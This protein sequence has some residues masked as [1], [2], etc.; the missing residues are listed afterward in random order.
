M[1]RIIYSSQRK[2]GF[3]ISEI[4]EMLKLAQENN[5]GNGLSGML[6]FG[7]DRFLQVLEGVNAPLE[8]LYSKIKKDD[9]HQNLKT[10]ANEEIKAPSF[11]L[12][13]M[14]LINLDTVGMGRGTGTVLKEFKPEEMSGEEAMSFL[15]NLGD[16]LKRENESFIDAKKRIAFCDDDPSI[17]KVMEL[18]LR[19]QPFEFKSYLSG[20]ELY[21]DFDDFKPD[22]IISD[23][24]MPKMDGLE[25]LKEIRKKD[26]YIPLLFSTSRKLDDRLERALSKGADGYLQKPY[27]QKDLLRAIKQ[28]ILSSSLVRSD[29]LEW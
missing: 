14:L 11:D 12:W 16:F 15:K 24:D 23:I 13:S 3:K 1:Q 28:A 26:F 27:R 8:A 18:F 29:I 19:D 10:I 20:V 6:V 25:L 17:L 5:Y 21:E 22:L 2:E 9:R 7:N 4:I